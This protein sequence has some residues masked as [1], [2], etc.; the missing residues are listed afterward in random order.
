MPAPEAHQPWPIARA[1][2][3]VVLTVHG[4]LD[5][6]AAP[7]LRG[8]LVDLIDGQGNL[9]VV[10]DMMFA[11]SLDGGSIDVLVDASRRMSRRGGT[12][13]ISCTRQEIRSRLAG[14]GLALS[15]P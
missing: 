10:V 3:R 6:G 4:P 9:D 1:L 2:G 14:S 15:P 13:V 11:R 7:R 12:L 8:V 5:D